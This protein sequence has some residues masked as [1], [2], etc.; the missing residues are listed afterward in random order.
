MDLSSFR[1]FIGKIL[2]PKSRADE[3]INCVCLF[4]LPFVYK[5]IRPANITWYHSF[6]ISIT[7]LFG[8]NILYVVLDLIRKRRLK[9]LK[10]I[11]ESYYWLVL[12]IE[13][14]CKFWFISNNV[15][16]Q[17]YDVLAKHVFDKG[18]NFIIPWQFTPFNLLPDCVVTAIKKTGIYCPLSLIAEAVSSTKDNV[19]IREDDFKEYSSIEEN[20]FFY[21][22]TNKLFL[23]FVTKGVRPYHTRDNKEITCV[24]DVERMWDDLRL[25]RYDK[26]VIA[27]YLFPQH[28]EILKKLSDC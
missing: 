13:P 14:N 28:N 9:P 16:P 6:S 7:L 20:E 1:K 22:T 19:I 2:Y 4:L 23:W 3:V 17:Y 5:L 21:T 25:K 15:T 10:K 26:N 24:A 12:H 11:S 8:F 27:G 18:K